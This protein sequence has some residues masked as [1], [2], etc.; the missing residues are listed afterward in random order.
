MS[1]KQIPNSKDLTGNNPTS[2]LSFTTKELNSY[3]EMEKYGINRVLVT[4]YQYKTLRFTNLE[5]AISQAKRDEK[6]NEI[7]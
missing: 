4:T 1:E 7:F 5:D 6:L 2:S 3:K